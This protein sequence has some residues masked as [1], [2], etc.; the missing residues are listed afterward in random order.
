M[1]CKNN[2][3]FTLGSALL[4]SQL[5]RPGDISFTP[6][7]DLSGPTPAG[8]PEQPA[9]PTPAGFVASNDLYHCFCCDGAGTNQDRFDDRALAGSVRAHE[10]D[11]GSQVRELSLPDSAQALDFDRPNHGEGSLVNRSGPGSPRW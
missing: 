2:Q 5:A 7:R 8:S 6:Y 4:K 11:Q 1:D 9:R 10:H 3:C